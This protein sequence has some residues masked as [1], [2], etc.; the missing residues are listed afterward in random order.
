MTT[1]IIEIMDMVREYKAE[2]PEHV[3]VYYRRRGQMVRRSY[4]NL[5]YSERYR[6]LRKSIASHRCFRCADCSRICS[7]FDL[8]EWTCDFSDLEEGLICSQCYESNMGDDL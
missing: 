5:V 4:D 6:E 1:E 7:Y 8:E 3:P 2:K